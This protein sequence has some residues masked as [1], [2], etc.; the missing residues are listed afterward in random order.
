MELGWNSTIGKVNYYLKGI[1]AFNRNKVIEKSEAAKP[2]PY[3]YEAGLPIKQFIGY[4]YDGFF[5]S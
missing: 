4:Q 3:M 5:S 2:Y 1:Y